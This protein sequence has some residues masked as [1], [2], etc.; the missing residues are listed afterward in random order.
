MKVTDD[1]IYILGA[2]ISVLSTQYSLSELTRTNVFIQEF[3][4]KTNNYLDYLEGR[5]YRIFKE[6]Y[7]L[8]EKFMDDQFE[9][10]K[11]RNKFQVEE[12]LKAMCNYGKG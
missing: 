8:D 1:H 11:K 5:V 9:N 3:K 6:T 10:M 2:Y 4:K 12:F 7:E